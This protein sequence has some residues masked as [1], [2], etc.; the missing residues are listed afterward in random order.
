MRSDGNYC[1]GSSSNVFFFSELR[2]HRTAAPRMCAVYVLVWRVT[3][4]RRR[5]SLT[6]WR[7]RAGSINHDPGVR[8][9]DRSIGTKTTVVSQYGTAKP[10]ARNIYE[11]AK[12]ALKSE[13]KNEVVA[14]K[15][16]E[17]NVFYFRRVTATRNCAWE[18]TV[19]LQKHDTTVM[20]NLTGN[21]RVNNTSRR[22]H[23]RSP[24]TVYRVILT[25]IARDNWRRWQVF[26]FL[27]LSICKRIDPARKR[28]AGLMDFPRTDGRV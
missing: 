28:T 9:G 13:N 2:Y 12:H 17:K 20:P 7:T 26:F 15:G 27:Q 11:R 16:M 21:R 6:G 19:E 4:S 14:P 8:R 3:S 22:N 1:R 5:P 24:W 10:C 25:N 23:Y 18:T